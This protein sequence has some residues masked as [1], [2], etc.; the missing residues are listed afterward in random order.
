MLYHGHM[1]GH[2]FSW[3]V[4]PG[5]TGIILAGITGTVPVSPDVSQL[6]PIVYVYVCL[7]IAHALQTIWDHHRMQYTLFNLHR[8]EIAEI[9]G[10]SQLT[11]DIVLLSPVYGANWDTMF[12]F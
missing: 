5:L 8:S 10:V 11:P 4:N 3:E 1:P 7:F 12:F 2:I 9:L 6:G